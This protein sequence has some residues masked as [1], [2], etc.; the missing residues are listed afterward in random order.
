LSKSELTTGLRSKA[1]I[2]DKF[3]LHQDE[4]VELGG[5]N[6]APNPV[7]VTLAALGGCQE[8]TWKAF[9]QATGVPL[10]KVSV[11][12]HGDLDLR[13]FFVVSKEARA[14]FHTI[15]GTVT[16]T[17]SASKERLERLKEVVDSHCPVKDMLSSV[18]I[19]IE[20]VHTPC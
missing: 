6:T 1:V 14:G 7:E 5:T 3:V 18:P 9:G 11:E 13:G 20:L 15:R 8:I 19:N 17:S 10:E 4:P 2:R 12:V 16:V